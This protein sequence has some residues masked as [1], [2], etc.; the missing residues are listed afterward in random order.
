MFF[1]LRNLQKSIMFVTHEKIPNLTNF[2]HLFKQKY[3]IF[4]TFALQVAFEIVSSF[5]WH[6]NC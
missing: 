3:K 4:S 1:V 6:H 2:L 5:E